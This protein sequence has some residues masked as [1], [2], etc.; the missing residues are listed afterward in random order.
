MRIWMSLAILF[1]MGVAFGDT[2][3]NIIPDIAAGREKSQ[4]CVSCHMADGNSVI[5]AWPNI[6]GLPE[7]YFIEQ[8][9]AFKAGDKGGRLNPVMMS[10]AA[11][12][13]DQDMA[14]LAAFYASQKSIPGS[15]PQTFVAVGE[16]IYRGGNRT[17][18]VPACSACHSPRA[19]GNIPAGFPSLSGQHP[20]YIIEQLKAFRSGTRADDINGIMR[21][22]SK[23]MTDEEIEAVSHYVSGLH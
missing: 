20:D 7:K 18:G 1:G 5:P 23:R 11:A 19:E 3:P 12:L 15:V 22:I 4:V 21:D 9:K 16:K 6:A 17:T 10:F 8:L 13:S 2:A 14:D